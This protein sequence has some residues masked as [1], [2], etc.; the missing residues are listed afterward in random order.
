[1]SSADR[2]WVRA[3]IPA[4]IEKGSEYG[5]SVDLSMDPS[6]ESSMG[7]A[8]FPISIGPLYFTPSG[9]GTAPPVLPLARLPEGLRGVA[10]TVAS[11]RQERAGV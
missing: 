5:S 11:G 2:V 3:R 10:A 4:R 9:V 6:M 7:F 1:M 8:Q